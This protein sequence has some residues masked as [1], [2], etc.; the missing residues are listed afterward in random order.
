MGDWPDQLASS[1]RCWIIRLRRSA[2]RRSLAFTRK[3]FWRVL[4]EVFVT[5]NRHEK[6]RGFSGFLTFLSLSGR[7]FKD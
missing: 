4:I 5:S 6:R 3:S 7:L 2:F 1:M